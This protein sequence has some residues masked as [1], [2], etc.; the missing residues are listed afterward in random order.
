M[1]CL[2][3]RQETLNVLDT[4]SWRMWL[5]DA[6]GRSTN[7]ELVETVDLKFIVVG[8]NFAALLSSP[9]CSC[10]LLTIDQTRILS[11]TN[12]TEMANVELMKKIVQ[13]IT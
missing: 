6:I 10:I 11:A 2:P 4:V 5:F 1:W 7:E 8:F 12:G 9:F 13:L 3:I